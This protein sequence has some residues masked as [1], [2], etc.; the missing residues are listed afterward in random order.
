M[1][2]TEIPYKNLST[3]YERLYE[4]LINGF[5]LVGLKYFDNGNVAT[6]VRGRFGLNNFIEYCEEFNIHFFDPE[7]PTTNLIQINEPFG[8]EY[9][10][11]A[12]CQSGPITNENYCPKCG[13]KI[14]K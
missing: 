10:A 7:E 12:C 11:T 1:K 14:K 3:D 6:I 8:Y 13:R 9:E 2:N 5:A 4:Y